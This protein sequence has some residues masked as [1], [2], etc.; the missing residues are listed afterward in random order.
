MKRDDD[1][2]IDIWAPEFQPYVLLRRLLPEDLLAICNQEEPKTSSKKN[3]KQTAERSRT[4][5]KTPE[6][7]ATVKKIPEKKATVKSR[8]TRTIKE[9][10]QMLRI[11][12]NNEA[13]DSIEDEAAATEGYF[14]KSPSKAMTMVAAVSFQRHF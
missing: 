2:L 10:Q 5:K 8:R 9:T 13:A 6:K 7:K 12:H 11:L 1:V 3:R 14:Q 4:V